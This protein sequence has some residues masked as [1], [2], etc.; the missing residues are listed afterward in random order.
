[1]SFRDVKIVE[2]DKWC[3]K[4]KYYD[5][6]ESEDPCWDCLCNTVNFASNKPTKWEEKTNDLSISYKCRV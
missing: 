5:K 4:C 3:E 2:F 1:M 6:K